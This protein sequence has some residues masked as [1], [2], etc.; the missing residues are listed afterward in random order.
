MRRAYDL[1][2]L[3]EELPSG[4]E[5]RP[6]KES[7]KRFAGAFSIREDLKEVAK[8]LDTLTILD[9]S[10][11]SQ[12]RE[13]FGLALMTL[14]VTTYCRAFAVN[15]SRR[16]IDGTKGMSRELLAKHQRVIQLRHKVMAHYDDGSDDALVQAFLSERAVLKVVEAGAALSI[17][18]IRANYLA[19]LVQDIYLLLEHVGPIV[20]AACGERMSEL[21]ERLLVLNRTDP[22]FNKL[23][24]RCPFD[25]ADF[26][27]GA[28]SEERFWANEDSS[29]EKRDP[30]GQLFP[31]EP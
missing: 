23:M 13:R 24:E 14:T 21:M 25:P 4:K 16:S 1:T 28:Y 27:R 22:H 8:T 26:Y 15:G 31:L 5:Y 9:Q 10:N 30:L 3:L 2:S 17:V 7:I 11:V 12:D 19:Q 29:S 18:L 6:L 20:Q